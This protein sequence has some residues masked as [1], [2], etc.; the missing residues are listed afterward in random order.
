MWW[1]RWSQPITSV[2]RALLLE[3]I[4]VEWIASVMFIDN[5]LSIE[6]EVARAAQ[7]NSQMPLCVFPFGKAR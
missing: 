5:T 3:S 4:L 2:N 6:G 1:N 7:K